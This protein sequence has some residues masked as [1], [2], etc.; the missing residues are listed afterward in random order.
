MG[1]GGV[2]GV[3]PDRVGSGQVGVGVK[4]GYAWRWVVGRGGAGRSSRK[5]SA[6]WAEQSK[7]RVR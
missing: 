3:G 1:W 6:G 5:G 2:D 4:L 7:G